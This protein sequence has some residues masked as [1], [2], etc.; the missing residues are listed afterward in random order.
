[1][2]RRSLAMIVACSAV[3]AATAFYYSSRLPSQQTLFSV[4]TEDEISRRADDPFASSPVPEQAERALSVIDAD[5]PK[6]KV[7]APSGFALSPPVDFDVA[8]EP[9]N[10]AAVD[11]QTLR[12]DY[13]IG[14]AWINVTSK[15]LSSATIKG[16]RL[17]ARG[18]DLPGGNHKLRFV[19]KDTANKTTR[20]VV[21]FSVKD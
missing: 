17:V 5:G 9:R 6:I 2:K 7:S 15:I 11:M 21:T 4:L 3:V 12:I 8:F 19:I 14:P 16:S 20:A 10:G 13:R 18:A 1:M